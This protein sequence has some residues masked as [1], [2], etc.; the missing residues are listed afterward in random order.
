MR[1]TLQTTR[2][3]SVQTIP[4]QAPTAL[5]SLN[6]LRFGLD[7]AG[8]MARAPALLRSPRGNG[9]PVICFPGFG[10]GDGSTLVLRRFL[11]A[12]GYRR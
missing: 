10:G 8:L 12:L 3:L 6:E 11:A 9:E 1:K 7:V 2:E 4:L 5:Q